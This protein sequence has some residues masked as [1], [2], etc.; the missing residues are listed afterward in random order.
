M[1]RNLLLLI[2]AVWCGAVTV[3]AQNQE[4]RKIKEPGKVVFHPHWFIQGQAGV[5]H[6]VG[7]GK[8]GDLLSPA[9]AINVGYKFA[10]AFGVRIG[11]SGW[12]AK[13]AWASP[14]QDYQFKYLQANLDFMVDLSTLFCGFNPDRVFNGYLLA[15][16]GLNGAFDNDEAN[17]LSAQGHEL[18]Y[19]WQ[20]KKVRPAGRLGLGCDFR[21]TER[22]GLNLEANA[23]IISDRFNSKKAGNCDWQFNALVGFTV[24]LGKTVE[25]TAPVYYE[26]EPV[27]PA[28]PKE[29]PVAEPQPAP[30]P[31]VKKAEPMR[32]DVF[33]ALN[34]ARIADGQ[35]AKIDALVTYMKQNPDSKVTVTGYADKDTGNAR[36]NL[37]LSE[38]RARNVAEALKTA[39]IASE[40]IIIDFKGDTVQ[41]HNTPKENRVSICVAE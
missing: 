4:G 21:L 3:T 41:P 27:A 6:T 16:A 32:Q 14:R 25:R 7:E 9:A 20:G 5:A 36:I 35:R 1:K 8:F 37:T 13:G 31:E 18:A 2:L 15:G 38:K 11:G 34:S 24:K 29:E 23:N 19:L 30:Q 22:L 39:G 40:R 17:A 26:P 28:Q 10:P 12:Q 33:F